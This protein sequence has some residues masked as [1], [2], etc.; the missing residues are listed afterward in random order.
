M[1][2]ITEIRV[3]SRGSRAR[4]VYLDGVEWAVLPAEVVRELGLR[5][6]QQIEQDT[7]AERVIAAAPGQAWQR[8][9]KLLN[10]R[11][12]GSEELRRRLR[13]DG[14]DA[15]A[16]ESAVARAID[17]GFVDDRRFAEALGR[18]LSHG[19]RQGRRRVARELAAKGVDEELAATVLENC[20]DEESERGRAERLAR[21]LVQR[22]RHE[23]ARVASR[24]V[25]RGYESGLAWRVAREACE[26]TEGGSEEV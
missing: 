26:A 8:V 7:L 11:E 15:D 6:G 25:S 3:G 9:L 22:C 13:D 18:A 24:L 17:L 4:R 19:K 12:R 5:V 10:L 21:S 23:P 14:Y 2:E 20:C 1:A 16:A